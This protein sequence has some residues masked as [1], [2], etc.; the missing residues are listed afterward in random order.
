MKETK[1]SYK[2]LEAYKESKKL[3]MSIYGNFPKKSN[4]LYVTSCVVL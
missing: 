4:M 1:Y 3:V 2:N